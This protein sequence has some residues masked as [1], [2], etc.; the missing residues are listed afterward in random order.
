MQALTEGRHSS[1]AEVVSEKCRRFFLLGSTET[2]GFRARV[3]TDRSC[4]H[5]GF[6]RDSREW[7]VRCRSRCHREHEDVKSTRVKIEDKQPACETDTKCVA[8]VLSK[9]L[10][11]VCLT[12]DYFGDVERRTGTCRLRRFI[13]VTFISGAGFAPTRD[14]FV[15][16]TGKALPD[17]E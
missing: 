5:F 6:K 12:L 3:D 13:T 8:S 17:Q 10:K 9:Y 2:S 16:A 1:A 4:S 11:A 15:I 14:C 7:G